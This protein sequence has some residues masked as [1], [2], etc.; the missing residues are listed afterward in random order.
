ME[1]KPLTPTKRKA[2]DIDSDDLSSKFYRSSPQRKESG[3]QQQSSRPQDPTLPAYIPWESG[4]FVPFS[5]TRSPTHDIDK[6]LGGSYDNV[7][8]ISLRTPSP[9][10][11]AFSTNMLDS[12][13][14]NPSGQQEMMDRGGRIALPTGVGIGMAM[15][16]KGYS[17]GSYVPELTMDDRDDD[18]EMEDSKHVEFADEGPR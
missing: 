1:P 11:D 16:N 12:D 2:D 6:N 15:A 7:I 10:Q 4:P 8:P 9:A 17:L 5:P 18:E 14:R 3:M 13:D